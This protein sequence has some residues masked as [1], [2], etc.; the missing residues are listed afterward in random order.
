MTV[1][2]PKEDFRPEEEPDP[3]IVRWMEPRPLAVS[4]LGVSTAIAGAFALG[5]LS[6]AVIVLLP[7]RD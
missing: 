4:R 2:D 6:A 3:D 1:I 7:R 5:A